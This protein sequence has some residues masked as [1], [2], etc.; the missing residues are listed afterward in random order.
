M[1]VRF[2]LCSPPLGIRSSPGF[3]KSSKSQW[4]SG[5][6]RYAPT[7]HLKSPRLSRF[8]D[9]LWLSSPPI[10]DLLEWWVT[11][12]VSSCFWRH[13][14]L[15][16]LWPHACS[17]LPSLDGWDG[18]GHHGRPVDWTLCTRVRDV[19]GPLLLSFGTPLMT[20]PLPPGLRR[21]SPPLACD[22]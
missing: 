8:S 20:G 9:P 6:D 17:S 3:L 13:P 11:L 12:E 16:P 15:C 22:S 4:L 10:C 5:L 21:L 14:P 19:A 1:L 18:L 7:L 2:A